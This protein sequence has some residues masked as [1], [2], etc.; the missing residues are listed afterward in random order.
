MLQGL[1]YTYQA[2]GCT[3]QGLQRTFQSLGY[4]SCNW[5]ESFS[6]SCGNKYSGMK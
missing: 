1:G 5:E 2:L 3:N 4:K 6:L